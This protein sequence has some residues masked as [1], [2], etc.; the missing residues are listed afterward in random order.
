MILD[1]KK[2]TAMLVEIKDI[3]DELDI[4]KIVLDEQKKTL[5]DMDQVTKNLTKKTPTAMITRDESLS[6]GNNRVLE[7][8]L[9]RIEKMKKMT[10]KSHLGVSTP[11]LQHFSEADLQSSVS[12]SASSRLEAKTS[13]FL[14]SPLCTKTIREHLPP[15]GACARDS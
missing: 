4:L 2:E 1:I 12:A 6:L 8:H 11:P 9:Y 7:S 14:R 13:Q 5:E 15:G 10:E 3:S